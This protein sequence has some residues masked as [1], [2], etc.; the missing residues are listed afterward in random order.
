L[1]NNRLGRAEIISD[2]IGNGGLP[3]YWLEPIFQGIKRNK[4]TYCF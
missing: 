4:P 2:A 3:E 1:I